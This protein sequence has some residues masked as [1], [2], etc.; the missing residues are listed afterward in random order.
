MLVCFELGLKRVL[1]FFSS[2]RYYLAMKFDL[3]ADAFD[4]A[5]VL[6]NGL[7]NPSL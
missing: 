7:G 3:W 2:D 4:P 1:L 5:E 6:F